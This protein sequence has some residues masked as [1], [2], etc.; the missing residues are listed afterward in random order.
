MKRLVNKEPSVVTSFSAWYKEG[1]FDLGKNT[2]PDTSESNDAIF[3]CLG[4]S[5]LYKKGALCYWRGD[6]TSETTLSNI[7]FGPVIKEQFTICSVTCQN[8]SCHEISCFMVSIN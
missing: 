1:S 4:L 2:W 5:E 8:S 7:D 3:S 6:G